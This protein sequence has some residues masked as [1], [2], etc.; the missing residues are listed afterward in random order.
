MRIPHPALNETESAMFTFIN[1]F[2][3]G[4]ASGLRAFTGLAVVS[5]AAHLGYIHLDHT[6]LAFLGFAFTPYI[7][8]LL[9]IG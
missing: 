5:W 9:A 3:L 1:P 2:L 8:T 6:W 7:L 4:A